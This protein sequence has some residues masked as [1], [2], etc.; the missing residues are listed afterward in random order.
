MKFILLLLFIVGC[1]TMPKDGL[2]CPP[3]TVMFM[4]G[5]DVYAHIPLSELDRTSIRNARKVCA[6]KKKENPNKCLIL[7]E[8]YPNNKYFALCGLRR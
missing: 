4:E 2:K 3:L 5:V 6:S 8:I 7:L 1:A